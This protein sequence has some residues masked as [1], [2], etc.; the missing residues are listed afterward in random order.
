MEKNMFKF[1]H[2]FKHYFFGLSFIGIAAFVI[3]EIP[4]M[5]M[6]LI[7]SES[8]PIMNGFQMKN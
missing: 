8:N 1:V 2:L 6:P 4:Y 7:K 3:Q 5:I